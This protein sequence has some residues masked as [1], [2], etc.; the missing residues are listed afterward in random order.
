MTRARRLSSLLAVLALG[1]ALGGGG[2]SSCAKGGATEAAREDVAL[3]PKDAQILLALNVGRARDTALW[4][5]LLDV[6][7]QAAVAN[8][9][10]EAEK[11]RQDDEARK[12]ASTDGGSA[13]PEEA[14]KADSD[15]SGAPKSFE[16]FVARCGFDPFKQLDSAFLALPAPPTE[17]EFAVILRGSFDKA[18]LIACGKAAAKQ[19]G[20][21]LAETEYGGK[22]L[23]NDAMSGTLFVSFLDEQTVFVG[24]REWIKK[25][26]DLAGDTKPAEGQKVQSAKDNQPLQELVKRTR[27]ADAVWGVGVISEAVREQLKGNEKLASAG[28]MKNLFGSLDFAT[29]LNFGLNVDLGTDADAA[30]LSKKIGEQL[31]EAKKNSKVMMMGMVSF[32]E[33]IHVEAQGPALRLTMKLNQQQVEDLVN[34]ALGLLQGLSGQPMGGRGGFGGMPQ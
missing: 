17:G 15:P 18:K 32:I 34:R 9:R 10:A 26:I 2:C 7:D 19:A 22:K 13:A 27:T 4:R 30:E 21:D 25:M 1:G 5:R 14:A 20:R 12:L 33:A 6:R 3:V 23:Y 11:K 31:V 8:K 29:G 16:E 24:G 28:T